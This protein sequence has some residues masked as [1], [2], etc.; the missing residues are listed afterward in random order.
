MRCVAPTDKLARLGPLQA[1]EVEACKRG[2][3]AR[4]DESPVLELLKWRRDDRK[5]SDTRSTFE[6]WWPGMSATSAPALS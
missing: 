3:D 4:A 6:R 1:R 2:S 5:M